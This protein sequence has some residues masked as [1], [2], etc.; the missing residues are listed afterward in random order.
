[1]QINVADHR[2]TGDPPCS[3]PR[4]RAASTPLAIY[5]RPGETP[6][7][8]RDGHDTPPPTSVTGYPSPLEHLMRVMIRSCRRE[9][10]P[11]IAEVVA[12]AAS[13]KTTS[14]GKK[15]LGKCDR[16]SLP[17][18]AAYTGLPAVPTY[19]GLP[20]APT[21]TGLPAV[22]TYTGLPAVPTY[23]GLPAAPIYTGLP[24]AQAGSSTVAQSLVV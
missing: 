4:R 21:Y 13:V 16:L 15:S 12:A 10:H 24:A 18:R 3:N 9:T 2:V 11:Q 7:L 17:A 20:A 19:T 5:W 14:Y 23:T 1:M 22:P 8:L 6:R